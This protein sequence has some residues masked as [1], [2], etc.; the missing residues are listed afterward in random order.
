VT[1]QR[2]RIHLL[3]VVL[4][5]AL[6][7][8]AAVGAAS[9]Q[10]AA[11]GWRVLGAV[12]PTHLPPATSEVQQVSVDAT[13]GTF[14]LTFQAETTAPL[15]FDAAAADVEAALNSLATVGGAGGAVEV[16]GGPGDAGATK[17]YSV[18]FGGSLAGTDIAQMTADATELIGG[19]ATATVTTPT[20][21]GTAGKGTLAVY[22]TNVGGAPTDGTPVVLEIGPL[23]P[24]IVTAGFISGPGWTCPGGVGESSVV[25]TRTAEVDPLQ[26]TPPVKVPLSV[27]PAAP[28]SASVRVTVG[29]GG[30]APDLEGWNSYPVPFVVSAE[31][32]EPGVAAF[33]AGAFDENGRPETRAGAH[34][35]S[36]GTFFL[37]NSRSLP[38]AAETVVPAGD[39]KDVIADLPP[40]FVGNP[41]VTKRCP[42]GNPLP[43]IGSIL[44]DGTITDPL[45][46]NEMDIGFAGAITGL[47]GNATGSSPNPAA[48]SHIFNDV[49]FQ[50]YPATFT[51]PVVTAKVTAVA[52]LRSDEDYGV[53]V[54]AA[55]APAVFR[56]FGASFILLGQPAGAGGK[57]FLS[58]P[59]SCAEQAASTPLTTVSTNAWHQPSV[60][61]EHSVDIPPVVGCDQLDFK[62]KFT[63]Q[64]SAASAATPVGGV[65]HLQV[66]QAGL[67]DPA[68]LAPPHLKK[69]V[70]TLPA[71]LT[72]NPA[73][74]D[75]LL[76][77][78]TE[79][80]GLKT[81]TGAMPNPMRFD[82]APVA[83]PPASKI[84][85]A[86]IKTPLLEAPLN[87]NVYLA[88]QDE[89]PFR[90]LLAM[91]L[92]VD[93][94]RF[95]VTVKLAGR[96]TPDPVT[97]QLTAE[98]DNNPQVPF[99]DLTLNF[100]GGGPRSTLATPDVCGTY[101]TNGSFTPWSAPESGPPA[102]TAD[103]FAVTSGPGGSA[104]C[105]RTK[106]ERPFSLGFEAGSTH[107][108]GGAASPFTLRIT[109]PDGNQ[110]LD[111][112]KVTTPPGLLAS[113][114]GVGSCSDAQ[115]IAALAPNRTGKQEIASPSCPASSQVGTTTIGVGVGSSPLY[116]K[117]GKVYLTGPYRG[118]PLGLAFV[119]P[120]V[121]GP[122]DLGVQVVRTALQ[123]D[124]KTAQV[125]AVSDSIPQILKGIPLL[126]RDVRVDLDRPGFIRNPTNCETM[127]V[128]GQVTGGSGAV[129]NLSRRFQ[130]GNCANLGFKPH[131]KLELKGGTKRNKFQ[132]LTATVTAREG[133]AN[134]AGASVRFPR[135]I[136]LEQNHIRTVCTRVQFAADSCPPASIY[137]YAE[138]E[139]PLLD[140][141][142]KGP[143]YM[144]SSDNPLP[145]IVAALRGPDH[146]PIEVELAGRVDSKNRGIRNT[147]DIVPDAPVSKFTLRMKGG[148][149]SLLVS[150]R[151]LCQRKQRAV[152]K[153][154]G[155]NGMK[156]DFRP[157]LKVKCKKNKKQKQ[158]R[159]GKGKKSR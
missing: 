158:A 87:G 22:A 31:E 40:G 74:A 123:V 108:V 111:R 88:A 51:F 148:K 144:R 15:S 42:E 150:S 135:S 46:G 59:S 43:K 86:E 62:P 8:A 138:A 116:V 18:R 84:G 6:L 50:G 83:C 98:F 76:A 44:P 89:N 141:P 94:P 77:C 119:V 113:L 13:G 152:V 95:G 99:E 7:L 100:R 118:A 30:A 106:A 28:P 107:P 24:D 120:A 67:L 124:P 128:A 147:F 48:G 136:F 36:A 121:A 12:G 103:S 143:V 54:L 129:N 41:T 16:I 112:I 151:D 23:P 75:G 58:N 85:T 4:S 69:S 90:S 45:C 154:R 63:L 5:G 159:R 137:G 156:R 127:A 52:S 19:A 78:S 155:H 34:P 66:D 11:P 71:G 115:L 26:S 114:R 20:A 57:A 37:L 1:W 53:S 102:Q 72:L 9:G 21:G 25:C 61:D 70:V 33:W 146:Q 65:A 49:P 93:N 79:Q 32:A 38:N 131:L 149:R 82:K 3:I 122:F 68:Q 55:N 27:G 80:M 104:A 139:T 92:V 157:V 39:V 109:R 101:T 64:P 29:G 73:A 14:T 153:M 56:V 17:P 60:F 47:F 132:R 140:Q 97:G 117:T 134:I 126:V 133:D 130:V 81:T 2:Q 91:Y 35:H 142:L 145:D 10:A 105:P 125:T 96:V 110:E